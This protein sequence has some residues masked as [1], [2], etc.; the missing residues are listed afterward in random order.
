MDK[1][2]DSLLVVIFSI[3]L[4]LS[5]LWDKLKSENP[6]WD[7]IGKGVIVWSINEFV[8]SREDYTLCPEVKVF[9]DEFIHATYSILSTFEKDQ[10]VK[11]VI[12]NKHDIRITLSQSQYKKVFPWH[13]VKSIQSPT[14]KRY[15]QKGILLSLVD[16]T[17]N[18]ITTP[19][20]GHALPTMNWQLG[21]GIYPN[22]TF[23]KAYDQSG[24]P[25]SHL[26]LELHDGND[27][28]ENLVKLTSMVLNK[29]IEYT[30]KVKKVP[31]PN[32]SYTGVPQE[33]RKGLMADGVFYPGPHKLASEKR[34]NVTQV[35]SRLHSTLP[36]WKDWYFIGTK[37]DP[38]V[39]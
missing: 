33:K 16:D 17:I 30:P 35:F 29:E 31:A 1:H 26:Y 2:D 36:V 39:H 34:L 28:E 18:L 3:P 27:A 19:M 5:V 8:N 11:D 13:R 12:W 4:K 14:V 15:D 21:Q 10:R 37:K 32:K 25:P 38:K 24:K 6:L 22:V 9:H 23:Q 7:E 20:P